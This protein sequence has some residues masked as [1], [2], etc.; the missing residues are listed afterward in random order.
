MNPYIVE[1][2]SNPRSH[3]GKQPG[4]HNQYFL[5][6]VCDS[7]A[8]TARTCYMEVHPHTATVVLWSNL[9][10]LRL[11]VALP[12]IVV[13]ALYDSLFGVSHMLLSWL[14]K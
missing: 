2:P 12:V 3:R 7:A 1:T 6:S 8:V 11:V 13:A 10:R 4:L 5:K 14:M 9:H